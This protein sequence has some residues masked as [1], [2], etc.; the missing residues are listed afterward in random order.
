MTHIGNKGRAVNP[1]IKVISDLI[2]LTASGAVMS[3]TA[4]WF[5][6]RT[7]SDNLVSLLLYILFLPLINFKRIR[8]GT[9]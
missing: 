8:K 6:S 7:F 5:S 4:E 3:D 2:W 9:W 1:H